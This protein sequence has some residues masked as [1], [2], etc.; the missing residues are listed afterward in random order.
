M[1]ERIDPLEAA[2][3]IGVDSQTMRNWIR[4]GRI[5]ALKFGGRWK[6]ERSEIDYVLENGTREPTIPYTKRKLQDKT[7]G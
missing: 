1:S 5:K 7:S 4:H 6:V 2:R 3:I